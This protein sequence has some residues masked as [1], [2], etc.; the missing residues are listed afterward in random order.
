MQHQMIFLISEEIQKQPRHD[1]Q[2]VLQVIK[3]IRLKLTNAKSEHNIA[4]PE[5]NESLDFSES[6]VDIFEKVENYD[7][8]AS[9]S[10]LL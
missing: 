5:I 1:Y 4:P 6:P 10:H 2:N 7:L 3:N 8:P 9:L